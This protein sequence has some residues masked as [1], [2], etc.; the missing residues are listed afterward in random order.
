MG[1]HFR[2]IRVS[3]PKTKTSHRSLSEK[4]KTSGEAFATHRSRQ[5][6]FTEVIKDRNENVKQTA[7]KYLNPDIMRY[8]VAVID[9][10]KVK[11]SYNEKQEAYH[12]TPLG[13]TKQ[14]AIS[15]L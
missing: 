7:S 14:R 12:N 4:T 5:R 2:G 13:D 1:L 15:D 10:N 3:C 6:D 11:E 8:E 9:G